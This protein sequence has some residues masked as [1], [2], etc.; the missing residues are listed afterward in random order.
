MT[1]QEKKQDIWAK[2]YPKYQHLENYCKI[3]PRG[4]D[5]DNIYFHPMFIIAEDVY[6]SSQSDVGSNIKSGIYGLAFHSGVRND[7]F[8]VEINNDILDA[9]IIGYHTNKEVVMLA[10]TTMAKVRA[11]ISKLNY[12]TT[13]YVQNVLVGNSIKEVSDSFI[14]EIKATTEIVSFMQKAKGGAA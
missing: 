14:S 6:I 8:N 4:L 11:H 5:D 3:E 9:V 10:L 13:D 7:Y 2:L 1:N 12:Y